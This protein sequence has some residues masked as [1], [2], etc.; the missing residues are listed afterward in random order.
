MMERRAIG[1][2]EASV[3][4]LGCNQFG[5]QGCDAP[6]SS[7]VIGEAL[8]AGITYFDTADEYGSNYFDPDDPSGWGRSEEILGRAL[9][10]RRDEVVIATKFGVHPHG[11]EEHGGASARWA[12]QAVDDS[13]RRLAT[14]RIDLY[15]LHFP[16]TTVPIDETLVALDELVA[17]GKVREIGCCNFSA[18]QLEE[19]D[20]VAPG[21]RRFVSLQSALNLFQRG[22]V[23]D[24]LPT[25][26]RL[27]LAFIP[28]YPLASGMLTGKYR[29]GDVPSS[30]TRLTDQ[31]SDQ[32]RQRL[33]SDRTFDRL[34][35]LEAYAAAQGRTILE[36]AFAWL[37]AQPAV[38]TVIAGAAKPG[39]AA[40]NA[41]AGEWRLSR[42]E[43]A[44][45]TRVV[46]QA[47]APA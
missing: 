2:L 35:A 26:E 22:A 38:A 21:H 28:Y 24:L 43:A 4:G 40:A 42:D 45:V 33:F 29:R 18:D 37:L 11:D 8:D 46:E 47:T 36:L 19:A 41:A 31:V 9:R 6:T 16:D 10:S 17:D 44:A 20:A 12:K 34:E 25:C 5:T 39:Q 15:Q 13:L 7:R 30:G 1:T 3:V 14:D 23:E 27:G 32:A